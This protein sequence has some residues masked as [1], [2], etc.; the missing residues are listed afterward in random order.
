MCIYIYICIYTHN[1][2]YNKATH[3]EVMFIRTCTNKKGLEYG[4]RLRFSTEIYGSKREKT[5]FHEYLQEA[6]FVL[7]ESSKI[8]GNLREFTG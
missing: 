6:C 4:V 1:T 8:S 3:A 5:V 7:T 2:S